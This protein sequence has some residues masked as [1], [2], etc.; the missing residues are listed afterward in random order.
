MAPH[1][2][3][4]RHVAIPIKFDNANLTEGPTYQ[5]FEIG[6]G[7]CEFFS[8]RTNLSSIKFSKN[9]FGVLSKIASFPIVFGYLY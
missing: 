5:M 8:T 4:N 9:R 1:H 7:Q 2:V 6:R 3:V